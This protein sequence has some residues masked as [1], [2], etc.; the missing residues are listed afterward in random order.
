[1]NKEEALNTLIA[2]A[3]CNLESGNFTCS[4]CP[5][6]GKFI[7]DKYNRHLLPCIINGDVTNEKVIEAVK[8]LN[9]K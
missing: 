6:I 2:Y 8:I 1:M 9:S 3:I 5:F 7:I 4:D